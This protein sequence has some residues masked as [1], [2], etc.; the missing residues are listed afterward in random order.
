MALTLRLRAQRLAVPSHYLRVS[1]GQ[2]TSASTTPNGTRSVGRISAGNES[3]SG[4][5]RADDPAHSATDLRPAVA[6]QRRRMGARVLHLA[7]RP[8]WKR[9]HCSDAA[10]P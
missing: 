1:T 2:H 3:A 5:G 10:K 4:L 9:Q 7:D 8:S 6:Q